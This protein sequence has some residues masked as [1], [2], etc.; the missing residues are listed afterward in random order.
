MILATEILG[1]I[2]FG[3]CLLLLVSIFGM[4]GRCSRQEEAE[5]DRWKF[6]ANPS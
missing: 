1:G 4:S 3:V 2:A 6:D 5:Q